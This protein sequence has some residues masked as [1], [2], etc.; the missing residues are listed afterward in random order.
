[1][2]PFGSEP[3]PPGDVTETVLGPAR[4]TGVRARI[5]VAFWIVTEVAATPPIVTEVAPVKF[6]PVIMTS[7]PPEVRP[8][9][10]A[11]DETVGGAK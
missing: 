9:F 10:G 3:V 2:K 1:M 8:W 5:V 7:V 11:I 4:P 6:V